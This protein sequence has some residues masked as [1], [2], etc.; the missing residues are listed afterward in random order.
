[1]YVYIPFFGQLQYT[2]GQN[3][4]VCRNHYKVRFQFFEL[5]EKL[6]TARL[7]NRVAVRRVDFTG[8]R[9]VRGAEPSSFL[10]GP[11]AESLP[12]RPARLPEQFPARRGAALP[13]VWPFRLK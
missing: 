8:L 12:S 13:G 3:P 1:M 6:Y 4:T 11:V 2:L 10:I 7:R 9:A 5:I